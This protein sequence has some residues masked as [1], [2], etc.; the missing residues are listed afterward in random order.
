MPGPTP[1]T[2]PAPV[3]DRAGSR[4]AVPDAGTTPPDAGFGPPW[5]GRGPWGAGRPPQVVLAVALAGVQLLGSLGAAR[6][7]PERRS[8]DLLAVVLLLAGPVAL[9]LVTRARVPVVTVVVGAVTA[10]YLVLGYP[11]GPVVLSLAVALVAAVVTG[12]RLVAWL[13][14]GGVLTAHAVAV[15]LDPGRSWSWGAAAAT[16]AWALLVLALAEVGRVRGERAASHRRAMAEQRRRREGEERLRIARE[17]HDVVAHHMSLINVQASVALHLRGTHPE[18]VDEALQ[19]IKGASKEALVELR[20]LIEVLREGD[21][22][23]PRHPAASL[24]ALD[25][26]VARSRLAGLDLTTRTTGI[27][28]PLPPGVELAAYRVVQEAVTN[29]VR[30]ARASRAEVAVEHRPGRLVV[31]VDDDGRGVGDVDAL[32]EG[33]GIRGM[34]ERAAALGAEVR[35]AP[36]P[37][38]G[39]RV[40]ASFP[41]AAA[42]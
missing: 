20:S 21:G 36:S 28:Q 18:Q 13:V 31:T 37:L 9:A 30:H 12:H 6:A 42:S 10:A 14:A 29:V 3:G 35:L 11:Y 33:N 40:V 38:G 27:P 34:R 26:L 7:Q 8:L 19:V 32:P 2:P 15:A 1:R 25:D 5:A 17:L 4:A 24:A 16:L 22:P 39:L 41:T 23:A